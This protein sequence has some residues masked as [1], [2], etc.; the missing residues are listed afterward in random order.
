VRWRF[1]PCAFSTGGGSLR[2]ACRGRAGRGR[3]ESDKEPQRLN[4]FQ[5][6]GR[7]APSKRTSAWRR[8]DERG[9]LRGYR[10]MMVAGPHSVSKWRKDLT[11]PSR[12]VKASGVRR[13]G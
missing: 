5:S 7:R 2:D 12:K 10:R 3:A 13:E 4:D 1:A 9:G 8:D 6:K 11:L